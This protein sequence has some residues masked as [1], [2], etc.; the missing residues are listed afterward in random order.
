MNYHL[1]YSR[2]LSNEKGIY[3]I[4][5]LIKSEAKDHFSPFH[6]ASQKKI[7]RRAEKFY[8]VKITK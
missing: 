3:I 4:G 6:I 7:F 5:Y 1:L 2:D 8:L